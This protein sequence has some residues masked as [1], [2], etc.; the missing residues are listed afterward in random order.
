MS[1]VFEEDEILRLG[2][3]SHVPQDKPQAPAA[4][5]KVPPVPA[6]KA[7]SAPKPINDLKGSASS[8]D[9]DDDMSKS[10]YK[11]RQTFVQELEDE[12]ENWEDPAMCSFVATV[13]NKY[14]HTIIEEHNISLRVEQ[15]ILDSKGDPFSSHLREVML[16]HCSFSQYL[17][18]NVSTASLLKKI[19]QL[20]P[21]SS[22]ECSGAEFKILKFIAKGSFGSIFTGQ[23]KKT[24]KVHALKQEKPPSL[25]EYYICVELKDRL[26]DK[27]MLPAFMKVDFAVIANNSSV[28]ITDFSPYG[29]IVDVCNKFKNATTRNIEEYV[30]M[31]FTTQLLSIIDHL[32]GCKI[33]HADIKPDNFLV[34]SK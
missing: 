24:G 1:V 27:R 17:E 18:A 23:H 31:V 22:I 29:T 6:M 12:G 16:E 30:V 3:S 8:E 20:K 5:F 13:D 32:H 7:V 14:E 21:G 34:M 2:F 11:P 10:I 15:A 25:W 19:P 28:L 33:I 4:E 26:K 9:E